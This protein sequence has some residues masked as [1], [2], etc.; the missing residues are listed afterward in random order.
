MP[1]I[2]IKKADPPFDDPAADV[3][4]RSSDNVDFY[5]FKSLLEYSSSVFKD[6]FCVAQGNPEKRELK[7]GLQVILTDD[8]AETWKILLRFSYP[9]HAVGLPTLDSLD[10]FSRV[11]GSSR[12]YGMTGA[13]KMIV[14]NLIAP[15]FLKTE[16]MRVFALACHFGLEA[17]VR[18]AAKHTLRL[19][20][21]GRPY[22]DEMASMS[23][24]TY[25]RL[26]DWHIRCGKV[27]RGVARGTG[28]VKMSLDLFNKKY[29][30]DVS[31]PSYRHKAKVLEDRPLGVTVL[32]SDLIDNAIRE[33]IISGMSIR[34][35]AEMRDFGE[36]FAAEVDSATEKVSV[37][38]FL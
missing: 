1:T 26:Q 34:V 13:E 28:W 24:Q 19:P 33:A 38:H 9:Y 23:A 5:V 25:H 27:A 36:V 35:I 8:S 15:S 16:P 30:D 21:L 2:N 10:A 22:I 7:D 18:V 32:D 3:I 17:E 11:L 20:L 4:L 12:K 14:E 37:L 29:P 31:S 6:M